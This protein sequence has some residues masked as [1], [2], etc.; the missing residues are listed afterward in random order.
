MKKESYK[1]FKYIFFAITSS[2]QM[3]KRS[4]KLSQKIP[5]KYVDLS[6]VLNLTT[7]THLCNQN[8]WDC[9]LLSAKLNFGNYSVKTVQRHLKTSGSPKSLKLL[10][11]KGRSELANSTE[12]QFYCLFNMIDKGYIEMTENPAS[13]LPQV[14]SIMP[15]YGEK[16]LGGLSTL[17]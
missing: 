9:Q 2:L 11:I 3:F 14:F 10:G 8:G 1:I 17:H 12:T 15:F 7:F 6:V 13:L 5:L 16:N 4:A